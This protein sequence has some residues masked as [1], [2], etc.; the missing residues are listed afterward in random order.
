MDMP[1]WYSKTNLLAKVTDNPN[2]Y[3]DYWINANGQNVTII[4]SEKDALKIV[5]EDR[6]P[7]IEMFT[8]QVTI[9]FGDEICS[10]INNDIARI[11]SSLLQPADNENSPII[12]PIFNSTND[13]IMNTNTP[14]YI[15]YAR[16]RRQNYQ[17]G[18]RARDAELVPRLLDVRHRGT[19]AARCT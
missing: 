4:H 16:F 14:I 2:I 9:L 19:C 8:Q 3:E 1:F 7:T 11:D 13:I 6:I 12:G 18:Q 15:Y 5:K 17:S 10:T